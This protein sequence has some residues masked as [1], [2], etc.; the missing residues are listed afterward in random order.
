V[1]E[2]NANK[3]GFRIKKYLR[4]L[5]TLVS[6]SVSDLPTPKIVVSVYDKTTPPGSSSSWSS[7][8]KKYKM[9]ALA[10]YTY[11]SLENDLSAQ[12]HIYVVAASSSELC[13]LQEYNGNCN[14]QCKDRQKRT[15]EWRGVSR[16][17]YFHNKLPTSI[18]V[19][20]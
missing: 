12:A 5:K 10:G 13:V 3:V 7:W 2:K 9:G 15:S 16:A 14:Y 17:T 20:D 18:K 8:L 19:Q 11:V 1:K 4:H 6:V